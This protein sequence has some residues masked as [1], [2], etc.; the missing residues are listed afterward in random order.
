M[1]G[2]RV[3]IAIGSNQGDREE[4]CLR[5]ARLL[6]SSGK[7]EVICQSPLY[8]TEPWGVKEQTPFVN[9]AIE[10][11]TELAP[12]ALLGL[13]KSIELDMGRKASPRWSERVIDL[14]ILFFGDEVVRE[15]GL[16]VPHPRLCERAFVLVPLSDIAPEFVHPV[17]GKSVREMLA[18]LKD[19]GWV[20]RV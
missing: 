13:L 18:G 20:R 6:G 11:R 12:I 14:D 15:K 5:A 7:A 8:E 3:F 17:L 16:D 10:I 1:T 2:K 19:A 4:N 9:S